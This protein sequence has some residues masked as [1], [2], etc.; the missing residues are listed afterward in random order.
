MCEREQVRK[1]ESVR[2]LVSERDSEGVNVRMRVRMSYCQS[3]S[4]NEIERVSVR[5]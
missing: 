5:E 4:E 2:E 3:E 1:S